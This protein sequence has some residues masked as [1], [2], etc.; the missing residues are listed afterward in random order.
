[1]S[2]PR[3]L[4]EVLLTAAGCEQKGGDGATERKLE[5]VFVL[6]G[7]AA[8]SKIICK[9]NRLVIKK[10]KNPSKP[11]WLKPR[12]VKRRKKKINK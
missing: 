3:L 10:K 7:I 12:S 4:T 6:G 1:M 9:N 11:P 2:P 5:S 8:K